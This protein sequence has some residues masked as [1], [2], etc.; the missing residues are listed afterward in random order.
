MYYIKVRTRTYAHFIAETR[1]SFP[2][3]A[4]ALKHAFANADVISFI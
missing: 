4:Q 3:I 2:S 1:K